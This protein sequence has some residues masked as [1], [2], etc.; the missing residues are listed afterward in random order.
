MAVRHL[1]SRLPFGKK[2]VAI[3]QEEEPPFLSFQQEM[4]RFFDE[5]FNGVG[6]ELAPSRSRETG[7][8]PYLPKVD[9]M[10]TDK[11]IRVVTELPGLEAKDLDISLSG[12]VLMMTLPKSAEAQRQ[13]RRIAVKGA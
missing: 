9:V 6:T 3:C 4:N 10:E 8:S 13:T 12:D 1:V 7:L 5:F 11:E 2:P